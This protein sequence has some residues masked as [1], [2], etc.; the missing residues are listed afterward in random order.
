[1]KRHSTDLCQL[2]HQPKHQLKHIVPYLS[3]AWTPQT[4]CCTRPAAA[5]RCDPHVVQAAR[6]CTSRLHLMAACFFYSPV[7]SFLITSCFGSTKPADN[8]KARWRKLQFYKLL[9][10][11]LAAFLSLFIFPAVSERSCPFP[12]PFPFSPF[13]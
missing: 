13:T 3:E 9:G 7:P 12:I 1:M 8:P 4:V 10:H 5:S 6:Y 2:R 11:L